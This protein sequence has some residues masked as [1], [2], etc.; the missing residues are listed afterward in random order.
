MAL[1]LE[2]FLKIS[3]NQRRE[4]QELRAQERAADLKEINKMIEN[5]VKEEVER[6]LVPIQEE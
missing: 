5:G 3:Q 4:E 2:D 1:S 6:A